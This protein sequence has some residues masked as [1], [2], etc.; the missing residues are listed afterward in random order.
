M[1]KFLQE[2]GVVPINSFVQE[3]DLIDTIRSFGLGR[4]DFPGDERRMFTVEEMLE[5]LPDHLQDM[6]FMIR[7]AL[8][9]YSHFT[10]SQ[11]TELV[12]CLGESHLMDRSGGIVVDMMM[13]AALEARRSKVFASRDEDRGYI[14]TVREED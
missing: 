3:E 13:R 6:I 12:R 10:P 2:G 11:M 8:D 7:E 9:A 5:D 1:A 14:T 4:E